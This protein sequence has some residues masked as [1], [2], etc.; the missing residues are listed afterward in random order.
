[1][2]LKV[3]NV[4]IEELKISFVVMASCI[5]FLKSFWNKLLKEEFVVF[6]AVLGVLF[7]GLFMFFR[8]FCFSMKM[9]CL[10]SML[11]FVSLKL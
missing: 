11:I 10:R 3:V 4:R 6:L 2:F 7:G 8:Y 1:M 5:G 9:I